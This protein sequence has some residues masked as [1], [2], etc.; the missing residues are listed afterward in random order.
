MSTVWFKSNP[1]DKYPFLDPTNNAK[2]SIRIFRSAIFGFKDGTA[3]MLIFKGLLFNITK[4]ISTDIY[5]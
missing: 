3:P 4:Q 1:D 5:K 2:I